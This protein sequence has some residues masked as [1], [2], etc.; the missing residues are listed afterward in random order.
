MFIEEWVYQQL[1]REQREIRQ[2]TLGRIPIYFF[3]VGSE[4]FSKHDQELKAY[5]FPI[6][7]IIED[8]SIKEM[9]NEIDNRVLDN[10]SSF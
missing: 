9:V 4:V 6:T 1:I 3:K 10:L 5:R 2:I 8:N 7:K